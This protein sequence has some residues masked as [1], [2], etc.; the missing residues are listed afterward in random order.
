MGYHS[1][2]LFFFFVTFSRTNAREFPTPPQQHWL[3]SSASGAVAETLKRL[4]TR[5][6]IGGPFPCLLYH[7]SYSR[8][9]W[10]MSALSP[11]HIEYG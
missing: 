1:I 7:L 9:N 3:C 11:S 6:P 2:T 4:T 8:E 10:A 5:R